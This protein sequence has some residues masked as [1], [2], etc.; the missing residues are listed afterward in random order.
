MFLRAASLSA[1]TKQHKLDRL[2]PPSPWTNDLADEGV[3]VFVVQC[4]GTVDLAHDDDVD[5]IEMILKLR[6]YF[7]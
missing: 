4:A 5:W 7:M 3:V 2:R 6:L 1:K